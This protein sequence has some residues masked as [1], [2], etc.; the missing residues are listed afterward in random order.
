M[1]VFPIITPVLHALWWLLPLVLLAALLQSA[2]FKG[3]FGE[4]LVKSSAHWLLKEPEYLHFHNVIVPTPDGT[5]QI[6][7]IFVSA[8]GI[9]VVETKNL[10]GWIF[11]G[12][13]DATWTQK[14][15]K[16][17][18]RFQNPLRQ[19]YKHVKALESLLHLAP[20]KFHSVVVFV[21][22]STFKTPMPA[23]VTYGGGFIG[24]IKSK[25]NVLLTQS[26]VDAIVESLGT[27][28]KGSSR[29][30]TKQHVET[31]KSRA[32]PTST[33][34]CPKCGSRMVVRTAKTGKNPG[35]QFWGCS[36]F[37][38]CRITQRLS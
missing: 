5:T 17:T 30:E 31:L 10:R 37:P 19:N 26:E 1:T 4:K 18:A 36:Q 2:A 34:L 15:Y 33:R 3:A 24:F 20:D 32:D 13:N 23:N 25:S 16:K 29:A 6:D 22:D 35:S 12:E 38:K 7:H 14:L 27:L 9:F 8:Y 28:Q 11:G 21:G